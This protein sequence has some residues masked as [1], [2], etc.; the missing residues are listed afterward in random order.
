MTLADLLRLCVQAVL[1]A[2]VEEAARHIPRPPVPSTPTEAEQRAT[3]CASALA[4]RLWDRYR[5]PAGDPC[6][7]EHGRR[8]AVLY[9]AV[10]DDESIRWLATQIGHE[11]AECPD[12]PP[13]S[14]E[15]YQ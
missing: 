13:V 1:A 9:A 2:L 14:Q 10:L 5:D 7:S 4:G 11:F 3:M 12:K 15:V 8:M 6:L